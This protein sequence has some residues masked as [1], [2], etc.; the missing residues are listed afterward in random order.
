M[1]TPQPATTSSS[2]VLSI[3]GI[4]CGVLAVLVYPI[5]FG[6]VG[7][8]F[9]GIAKSKGERLSTVALVVAGVGMVIGVVV[10]A[11]LYNANN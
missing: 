1:T 9:G 7:L 11:L 4:V 5:L 10:G 2:N 8:I 3:I 6:P